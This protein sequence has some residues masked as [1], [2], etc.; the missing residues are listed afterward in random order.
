MS[1]DPNELEKSQN[2]S[3]QTRGIYETAQVYSETFQSEHHGTLF[4]Q[5]HLVITFMSNL[6]MKAW[7]L[8]FAKVGK[9]VFGVIVELMV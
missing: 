1:K 3:N 2:I 9:L 5:T 6:L 4:S 7:K 8:H